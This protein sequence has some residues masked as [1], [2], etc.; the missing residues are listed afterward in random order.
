MFLIMLSTAAGAQPANP[1]EDFATA[2]EFGHRFF[3]DGDYA[4]SLTWFE[5]AES[6]I[7][8]QPAILFNTALVLVKLQRYDE[9]QQRLERYLLLYPQG[10]EVQRVKDLQL[11]VKFAIERAIRDRQITEYKTLFSRARAL[12]DKNLRREA[13]DAFRQAEQID[14]QLNAHDSALY[15]NEAVL[16]EEEGDL[17]N[18]L[19]LYKNYVQL[20]PA[21]APVI[22]ARLIDLEREIGYT[23][24]KLLCPFC[25][26]I[27]PAGARWCHHCWHGPYDV[28]SSAWNARACGAHVTATRSFQDVNGKTRATES[29]DCAYPGAGLRE[30]LQYSHEGSVAVHNART[31]EGWSFAKE[32]LLEARRS[33]SGVDLALQHGDY[34]QRVD[35]LNT[36]EV[37]AY[38]AHATTDGIWLLDSQPFSAGDQRFLINRTFDNDGRV[39]REEVTYESAAC[40][41]TVT[42]SAAYTYS[43]DSMTSARFDGGYDGYRVEGF[44]QTRWEASLVRTLDSAGRLTREDI[45]VTSFQKLWNGKPQGTVSDEVR[46]YYTSLKV[47]KPMDIRAAGDVCAYNSGVVV[48]EA[49]DLRPFFVV[50]PAMAVRLAKGDVRV[51]VDYVYT[52]K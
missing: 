19:R 43:G 52:E 26:A 23:R 31:K 9:A 38:H 7:R 33:S 27:L 6:I 46:R 2:A 36:G 34:L 13:L 14:V 35:N 49:I 50:S 16:G 44:P 29:V 40:H 11:E 8:D 17:E 51:V 3:E 4:A 24:T 25:G 47:R 20:D 12:S 48:E 18:A 28:T 22:Q 15:Y 39:Q 5:K 32:G 41:H 30:Y 45:S 1:G 10:Q 37:F 42:A 21:N